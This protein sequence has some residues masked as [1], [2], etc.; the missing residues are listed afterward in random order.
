[1]QGVGAPSRRFEF[2]GS[3]GDRLVGRLELPPDGAAPRACALFAHCFTCSKDLAPATRIARGLAAHG[4]AV[5][6]FD[7]TGLGSSEG[8]F[9]NTDFSSNVEDLVR[10]ARALSGELD[11]PALLVGHS[12]GGAAVLSAAAR[13]PE[14]RAVATLGAPASPE[15]AARLFGDRLAEIE[16]RGEAEVSIAGRRFRIR[17]E[18]LDDL[19]GQ[20]LEE[21]IRGMRKALLVLHSPVDE[22]V[23]IENASRIFQAARHPKSFLSLDGADHLLSRRA[24]AAWA[25]DV[26]AVWASRYLPATAARE[27]SAAGP[28]EVV[29]SESGEGRYAQTIVTGPH[30]LRADE[31][32]EAGG[33]DTG[34]GPYDLLLAALGACTSMTLRMYAERK[35]LPLEHVSV[36]LH[37]ARIHASDCAECETRIGKVD[38]IRREISLRGALDVQQRARLLEIADRCPV[39]RTLRSEVRVESRLAD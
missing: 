18:L 28:G 12:L 3:Q 25:A 27:T 17:R 33:D 10:A 35:G 4:I 13:L 15:H 14:V 39:H 30:F 19:A 6:R 11:A 7:F 31:P 37:H 24:D 5:L 26:L 23:G 1:V 8:E 32:R 9:A 34:P 29:V 36:R 20:R 38:S 2:A 21:T 22:V 16:R